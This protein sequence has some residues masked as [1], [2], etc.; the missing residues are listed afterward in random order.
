MTHRPSLP[1]FIDDE[2]AR[3]P[4]LMEAVLHALAPASTA[5]AASPPHPEVQRLARH[6]R[7]ELVATFC[8]TLA[9]LLSTPAQAPRRPAAMTLSLV[10]DDAVASDVELSRA[11]ELIRSTAEFELRELRAFTSALVGDLH[12][13]RDTNPLRPDHYVRALW[14]AITGLPSSHNLRIALLRAAAAP[15]AQ[16][17][18][19]AY[20]AACTRLEDAGVVPSS[21]R[22]IV[23]STGSRSWHRSHT[24]PPDLDRLRQLLPPA[25]PAAA[26]AGDADPD[27]VLPSIF[28]AL[29]QDASV[30]TDLQALLGR[31][32]PIALCVARQDATTLDAYTHPLW[33]FIDRVAFLAALHPQADDPARTEVLAQAAALIEAIAHEA[34]PDAASFRWAHQRLA[35]WAR[36]QHEAR[37][38]SAS[39]HIA[40]LDTLGPAFS[41][42]AAEGGTPLPLDADSLDT[43][44]ADLLASA[45]GDAQADAAAASDA[46][47]W[48][49]SQLPE[50]WV[51]VFVDARWRHA[52]LLWHADD[53]WLY[54]EAGSTRQTWA[55]RQSALERLHAE[56]LLRALRERSL[57]SRAAARLMRQGSQNRPS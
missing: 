26:G 25:A 23:T 7:A 8:R 13:A 48:L 1:Q 9:G 11:T 31:L 39:A 51:R 54:A 29:R 41:P 3:A 18:R 4:L 53:L 57:V 52:Q 17:L 12:V 46:A 42:T 40:M 30:G 47:A 44:R 28:A 43:V 55:F 5:S 38:R 24:L 19:L 49:D 6:Y 35:H 20:A 10:E 16:A 2:V 37:L 14:A 36:Q 56:G 50:Q 33:V 21:Y 22:T 32:Q 15:L 45:N 27:T 34:T